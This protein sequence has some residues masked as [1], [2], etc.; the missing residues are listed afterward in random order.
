MT[1]TTGAMEPARGRARISRMKRPALIV[2]APR[3]RA[4]LFRRPL[5]RQT[6]RKHCPAGVEH[7]FVG[8]GEGPCAV[9]MIGPGEWTSA[10]TQRS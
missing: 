3:R 9:L 10:T 1:V 2:L 8:A 5:E 7:V 4:A 6:P